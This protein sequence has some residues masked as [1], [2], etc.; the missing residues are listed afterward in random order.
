MIHLFI[1]ALL[2]SGL[3]CICMC[4]WLVKAGC[5]DIPNAR[6]SHSCQT[7]T[8]GGVGILAGCS[9][10][11]LCLRFMP[12]VHFESMGLIAELLVMAGAVALIGLWDDFK[13][14]R[15]RYRL[16]L[17]LLVSL[18]V[19]YKLTPITA[20]PLWDDMEI[21]L[22]YWAGL[23]G[24]A[25]WIFVLCSGVNFMD[26]ANGMMVAIMAV[27]SAYL[28]LFSIYFQAM[29]AAVWSGML[30]GV[31]G[32][33]GVYNFRREALI[34]SGDVGSLLVGFCYG[35]AVILFCH[36]TSWSYLYI[37]P[38]LILPLL[39]DIFLTLWRRACA[40]ENLL[41]SHNK[42]LYQ[43]AIRNGYTHVQ[44]S[45]VYMIVTIVCG[46][47]VT[48]LLYWEMVNILPLF[49]LVILLAIVVYRRI[50]RSFNVSV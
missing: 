31:L 7:P 6:S 47:W 19:T 46:I 33:F 13:P 27:A 10:F 29:Q 21:S 49:W 38:C 41:L 48:G 50:L 20:L 1:G 34:F 14:V 35:M 2:L 4:A 45:L 28:A 40:G 11:F 22:P 3:V 23:G 43:L 17:L 37:G 24:T 9:V 18:Y 26:G 15:A 32:G 8:L 12:A 16:G 36:E 5:Q 42:H 25:L 44:V 39:T 30:V